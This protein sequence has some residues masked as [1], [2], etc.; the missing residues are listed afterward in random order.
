[1]PALRPPRRPAQWRSTAVVVVQG[2]GGAGKIFAAAGPAPVSA[3]A[4]VP[5]S[6][7]R[8]PAETEVA[9]VRTA[10]GR[11]GP[12]VRLRLARHGLA[13]WQGEP[14]PVQF[15]SIRIKLTSRPKPQSVALPMIRTDTRVKT[16][17]CSIQHWRRP[18]SGGI[19]TAL[20]HHPNRGDRSSV[21]AGRGTAQG[22][23]RAAA[24][25]AREAFCRPSSRIGEPGRGSARRARRFLLPR[26]SHRPRQILR[27]E[28]RP[29]GRRVRSAEAS[30]L[31]L[32]PI[33]Q[34]GHLC[35]ERANSCPSGRACRG[36]CKAQHRSPGHPAAVRGSKARG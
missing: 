16:S 6:R 15:R 4:R 10:A 2:A 14:E 28:R 27:V 31:T 32:C 33:R 20:S 34:P 29:N 18:P 23:G 9:P 24:C 25:P 30:A 3:A 22:G 8:W 21:Q 11:G 19:G 17:M 13:G 26:N 35:G 7:R 36:S 12:P 5:P 1:M